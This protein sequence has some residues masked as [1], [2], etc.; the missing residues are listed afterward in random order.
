MVTRTV[1]GVQGWALFRGGP[2]DRVEITLDGESVGRA[3]LCCPREDIRQ[4]TGIEAG[5]VSG[6][7]FELELWGIDEGVERA[8]I[9]ARAHGPGGERFELRAVEVWLAAADS[10]PAQPS[11][12]RTLSRA[13]AART[14]KDVELLV[15]TAPQPYGTGGGSLMELLGQVAGGHPMSGVVLSDADTPALAGLEEAG[16]EVHL[17][18]ALPVSE[19]RPYEDRLEELAAWTAG[20]RF[21]AAVVDGLAAFPGGDLALRLDIPAVWAIHET[22][23]LAS[24]WEVLRPEADPYVRWRAETALKSAAAVVF[25]ADQARR[26][27]ASDL[28]GVTCLTVPYG[29]DVDAL[30]NARQ[31]IDREAARARRD[32]PREATVILSTGTISPPEEQAALVWAFARV[33]DRHP[34]AVLVLVDELDPTDEGAPVTAASACGLGEDRIRVEPLFADL[35]EAYAIADLV[36][37]APGWTWLP[38]GMLEAIA[39]GLP[40]LGLATLGIP[41]LVEDGVTGWLAEPGDVSALAHAL[42]RVLRLEASERVAVAREARTRVRAAHDPRASARAW[43]YV[44]TRVAARRPLHPPSPSSPGPYA[45]R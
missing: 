31:A 40:V 24:H 2:P 3:R 20:R 8:V 41:D 44:L 1:L 32:I 15:A 14:H 29:V 21:D 10:G 12:T 38:Y 45:P 37:C 42:D 11:Y 17:T 34:G 27:F 35:R 13:P 25:E 5:G 30:D 36:V 26:Q 6:F 7:T 43:A 22:V 18:G 4:A 16:F 9:G 33:A 28:A 19:P 39:V 23:P